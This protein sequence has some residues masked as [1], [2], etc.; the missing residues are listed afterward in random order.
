MSD[1]ELQGFGHDDELEKDDVAIDDEDDS[2]D[3]GDLSLDEL[4]DDEE[5]DMDDILGDFDDR[6]DF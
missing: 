4:A 3:E 6:D 5:D 1:D 2:D